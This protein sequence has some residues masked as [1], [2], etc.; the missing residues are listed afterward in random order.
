MGFFDNPDASKLV[1]SHISIIKTLEDKE[2]E[3]LVLKYREIRRELRDR[4][5]TLP[6]NTFSAQQLRGVLIQVEGALDAMRTG[7]IKDMGE[8]SSEAAIL[9]S[10]HLIRETEKFN[11]IFTG[12]ASNINVNAASVALDTSNFL[13]NRYE[14]SLTEY[15]SG[16]RALMSRNLS[17]AVIEQAP[18]STV[19]KRMNKFL[20]GEEWK[21]TRL[22]RTELHNVYNTAK[23]KTL[24]KVAEIEPKIMKTLIHPMD[25][26]TG[27]DSKQAAKKNLIVPVDKP[28]KYTFTRKLKSGEIH[29][30]ERVFMVPP[31]RPNDRSIMVPYMEDWD[32]DA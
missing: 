31:D 6:E 25:L 16:I 27:D 24:F 14:S 7:L 13:F 1:Q 23:Q 21:L 30:E 2:A 10:D 29:R 12:A 4:L 28:F 17:Q 9:G 15:S 3:K 19:V 11:S 22:A 20:L 26:R 32:S 18:T 8:S 5:D